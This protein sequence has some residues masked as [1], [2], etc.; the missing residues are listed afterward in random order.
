ML[1]GI[2]SERKTNELSRRSM[3]LDEQQGIKCDKYD[4]NL[5]ILKNCITEIITYIQP[6]LPYSNIEV[7]ERNN[8]NIASARYIDDKY[9]IV[10]NS[11]V[12]EKYDDYLKDIF[13][14]DDSIYNKD[15]FKKYS[16]EKNSLHKILYEYGLMYCLLHEY[17]HIKDGHLKFLANNDEHKG[18]YET[19][20]TLEYH[21]D[22]GATSMMVGMLLIE[23]YGRE[24]LEEQIKLFTLSAYIM[25]ILSLRYDYR[26]D[27]QDIEMFEIFKD[28]HPLD[29][30]RQYSL[31][32][33]LYS[34]LSNYKVEDEV[35]RIINDVIKMLIDFEKNRQR[36][37]DLDLKKVPL[38]IAYTKEGHDSLKQIHNYW[39][40]IE[41]KVNYYSYINQPDYEPWV[42][43]PEYLLNLFKKDYFME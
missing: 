42:D 15:S 1:N 7:E 36:N 3:S 23:C 43:T 32:D 39:S 30:F 38:M 35:N 33:S 20:R 34:K 9:T 22:N 21:A 10:F 26:W 17:S 6:S 24:D 19:I 5:F 25:F 16:S 18:N 4:R 29:G 41:S 11:K 40:S 31:L 2:F 14:N 8:K 13:K 27:I 37:S 12:L 28:S